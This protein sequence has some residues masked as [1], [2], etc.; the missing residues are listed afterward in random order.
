MNADAVRNIRQAMLDGP[1]L[2]TMLRLA[3]PTTAVLVIQS[4]VSVAETAFIG[5][6]GTVVGIIKVFSDLK[7]KGAVKAVPVEKAADTQPITPGDA[8]APSPADPL[9]VMK[10][11]Q[12][13]PISAIYNRPA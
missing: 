5:L 7:T 4:V 10:A 6:L 9:A 3:G 1:V 12:G 11:A 2:P 8:D 13:K